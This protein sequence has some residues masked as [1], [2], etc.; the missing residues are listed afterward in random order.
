MWVVTNVEVDP[1]LGGDQDEIAAAHDVVQGDRKDEAGAAEGDGAELPSNE[2]I[3]LGEQRKQPHQRQREEDAR[4]QQVETEQRNAEGF[5]KVTDLLEGLK[6]KLAVDILLG[7]ENSEEAA[8]ILLEMDTHSAKRIVGA[9]RS[10]EQVTQMR[11][12]LRRMRDASPE[13][14]AGLETWQALQA[15]LD[16]RLAVVAAQAAWDAFDHEA[17][18]DDLSDAREDTLSAQEDL[19]EALEILAQH[20]DLDQDDPTRQRYEDDV[21]EAREAYNEA[22]GEQEQLEVAFGRL[23]LNLAL[24]QDQL[25]VAEAEYADRENGP[26]ADSV[27]QIRAQIET[28]EASIEALDVALQ[29]LIL[30]APF[31]GIV[32]RID[33][34][35]N[36]TAAAG[37]PVVTVADFSTWFAET[38][39]LN[40]LEVVRVQEGQSVTLTP[41]ALPEA[42]L[43]GTV[44]RIDLMPTVWQGDITYTVRIRLEPSELP[45]RW[46]MTVTAYFDE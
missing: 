30:T 19:D 21:A 42:S 22:F 1:T 6:P 29:N 9:A 36:D 17:Y 11:D 24:A 8:N 33:V 16:A 4:R 38:D 18:E 20:D 7:M 23:E 28:L 40:E 5:R 14:F 3:P 13:R 12:I 43:L 45:L 35:V 15:V 31:D 27:Q 39:D 2:H 10:A 44:E 26:D 46:G 37:M 32:A 25:T 41:E 34:Q